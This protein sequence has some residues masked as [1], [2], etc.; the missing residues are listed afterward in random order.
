MISSLILLQTNIFS[1]QLLGLRARPELLP[2]RTSIPGLV[3][4]EGRDR[5]SDPH[6]TGIGVR[7]RE[8]IQTEVSSAKLVQLEHVSPVQPA[9]LLLLFQTAMR[10]AAWLSLVHFSLGLPGIIKIGPFLN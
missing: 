9:D 3:G 5:S 1:R 4:C 2:D 6:N 10:A 8:V 7:A